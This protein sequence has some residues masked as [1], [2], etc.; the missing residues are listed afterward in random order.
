M[1]TDSTLAAIFLSVGTLSLQSLHADSWQ[2][3]RGPLNNGISSETDWSHQWGVDGPATAWKAQ[4]GVGFSG[5]SVAG[6]RVFTMGNASDQDSVVALEATQ[7]AELWRFAYPEA[8]NAKMYEGGPNSTPTIDGD[9][10]FAVSRS[11]KV[12]ALNAATGAVRWQVDLPSTVGKTK[13]D[14]GVSGSPLVTGDRVFI[15]YGNGATALERSSGK[16]LWTMGGGDRNS[17][18]TPVLLDDAGAEIL[19]LHMK[20]ELIGVVVAAGS[21]EG[22]LGAPAS[23]FA[24]TDFTAALASARCPLPI[25]TTAVE[26][27]FT[28]CPSAYGAGFGQKLYRKFFQLSPL[29]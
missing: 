6:G 21:G 20:K 22:G 13:N 14:W 25:E 5:I 10:V 4:V 26:G 23:S 27:A 7:G 24:G 18:C 12:H 15:N 16:V 1:R 3:R 17:F 28:L 9:L 29:W 19:L 11:G 2:Q 8:L